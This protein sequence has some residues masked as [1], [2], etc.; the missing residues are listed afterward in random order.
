MSKVI[1][2]ILILVIY[3]YVMMAVHELGHVAGS[4]VTGG[5]VD[6]VV[7]GLLKLSRTDLICNPHPLIVAWS[8]FAGGVVFPGIIYL[9]WRVFKIPGL[10]FIFGLFCFCLIVNGVYM[11]ADAFYKS[12][13]GKSIIQHGGNMWQLLVVGIFLTAFGLWL[14]DNLQRKVEVKKPAAKQDKSHC[15]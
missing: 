6:R 7:F 2:L 13:D 11:A 10:N 9:L 15:S 14:V 1:K 5:Q 3:W 8:G 4:W 12:A